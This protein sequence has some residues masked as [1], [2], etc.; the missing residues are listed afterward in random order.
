[1]IS[2]V[3]MKAFRFTDPSPLFHSIVARPFVKSES[4]SGNQM[5]LNISRVPPGAD[6]GN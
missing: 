6:S 1:M 2:Y 3:P 5:P 4:H